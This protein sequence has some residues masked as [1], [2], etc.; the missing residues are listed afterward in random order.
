LAPSNDRDAFSQGLSYRNAARAAA[1]IVES[2]AVPEVAMPTFIMQ[3]RVSVESL[4]QPRSFETLE[5]HVAD[6]IE[7]HCPEVKWLASYAVLGPCDYVDIFEAPDI[8]AA[9]RV[10]VLV[11]SYGRAHSE[12][13][14]ALEWGQFKK[15]L[16]GLPEKA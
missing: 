15:L 5:R 4:H 1:P 13:W 2:Y 10:S 16:Q 6:Q 12:V 9:T 7:S 8:E 14:P 3:T 11:R